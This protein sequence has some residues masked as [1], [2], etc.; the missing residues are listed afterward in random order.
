[1]NPTPT[2]K[3]IDL[4]AAELQLVADEGARLLTGQRFSRLVE[5]S[6]RCLLFCG[7]FVDFAVDFSPGFVHACLCASRKARGEVGAFTMLLRKHIGGARVISCA[8]PRTGDR[9]LQLAFSSGVRLSLELSGRH[10]NAFLLDDGGAILGS[11]FPTHS[12]TRPLST[13]AIYTLPPAPTGAAAA[14]TTPGTSR[15]P[16]EEPG[17]AVDAFFTAAQTAAA[18]DRARTA[19]LTAKTREIEKARKVLEH[20]RTDA[21][22]MEQR[23]EGKRLGDLFLAALH[24]WPAGATSY[25]FTPYD[26]APTE[27]LTL[28]IKCKTPAAAA[29]I[30]FGQYKKARRSRA[31]IEERAAH[32]EAL[33]AR[34]EEERTKLEQRPPEFF[35]APAQS[36][37]K[38]GARGKSSPGGGKKSKQPAGDAGIRAFLSSDG[39]PIQVGKSATDNH[40]LTFQRARGADVWLHAR[41]VPGSHTVIFCGPK[42]IFVIID[43]A[44][45]ERLF[46][47][48]PV[49]R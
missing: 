33:V 9:I 3:S 16:A 46:A 30:H 49:A 41:D 15:F 6:E 44:V 21:V 5:A 37:P 17:A 13:G 2:P 34:L 18:R 23:T 39:L 43:P 22:R 47:G 26:G 29:Q 31:V 19:A 32:F 38:P 40:R 4:N 10:A 20:L 27:T 25:T 35:D 24:S 11:F 14:S 36:A 7:G 45:I 28:P 42:S 48:R 12:L 1:M 8:L